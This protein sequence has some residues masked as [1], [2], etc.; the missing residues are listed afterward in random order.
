MS[1]DEQSIYQDNQ[2]NLLNI[3]RVLW[4][5]KLIIIISTIIGIVLAFIVSIYSTQW[6]ESSAEITKPQY[7]D[8][9]VFISSA[10]QLTTGS[11]PPESLKSIT[12]IE[13]NYNSFIDILTSK[14][15][16]I[17]FLQQSN[18]IKNY[19]IRDGV[20]TDI[21]KDK[22]LDLWAEKIFVKKES[23]ILN[24]NSYIVT[25]QAN[26]LNDS[27]EILNNYIK[28]TKNKYNLDVLLSLE[29][30]KKT[31]LLNLKKQLDYNIAYTLDIKNLK[32]KKA[33]LALNIAEDS[34]IE[35]PLNN[36][37]EKGSSFN[38]AL[39]AKAL[40][41]EKNVITSLKDLAILN[42][43]ITLLSSQLNYL[44]S[45][46]LSNLENNAF[47]SYIQTEHKNPN[48]I[49]PSKKAFILVFAL[50][51]ACIGIVVSLVIEMFNK[52]D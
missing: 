45:V 51:F 19:L 25:A 37:F 22:A 46:K 14:T 16:K 7:S 27:F 13:K 38:I 8:Y 20:K 17:D 11:N 23:L 21:Q 42:D 52:K 34:G 35:S 18:I 33:Q 12:N 40:R 41:A 15:N 1:S 5:R 32:E 39:G 26:T 3:F 28:F 43:K 50:L 6:W 48:K 31:E 24:K 30:F 10:D 36:Y 9:A 47:F 44:N 29:K 49:A 2:L 4:T